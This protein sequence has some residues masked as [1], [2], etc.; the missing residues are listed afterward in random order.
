[1]VNQ[2]GAIYW[3]QSGDLGCD[4]EYIGEAIIKLIRLGA[5]IIDLPF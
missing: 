2:S 1:M 3:Y 5:V 4:D